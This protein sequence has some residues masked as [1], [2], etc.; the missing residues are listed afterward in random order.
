MD[1]PEDE[2]TEFM[3]QPSM[4][5]KYIP[6]KDPMWWAMKEAI[7]RDDDREERKNG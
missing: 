7:E 1:N 2:S 4:K 5:R 3:Y 6:Q